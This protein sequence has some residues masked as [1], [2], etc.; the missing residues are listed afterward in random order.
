ML[1]YEAKVVLHINSLFQ[2]VCERFREDKSLSEFI[3]SKEE[4][5]KPVEINLGWDNV[6]QKFDSIQY[7]SIISTLKILLKDED[8][9]ASILHQ[10]N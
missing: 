8:V 1:N 10:N 7:V 5:L 3:K 2:R 4:F 9:L 6:T